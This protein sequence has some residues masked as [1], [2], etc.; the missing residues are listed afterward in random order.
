MAE[1]FAALIDEKVFAGKK[2]IDLLRAIEAETGR[3][4][5]EHPVFDF[6]R[7]VLGDDPEN[8]KK[9]VIAALQQNFY[10]DETSPEHYLLLRIVF[11]RQALTE[12]FIDKLVRGDCGYSAFDSALIRHGAKISNEYNVFYNAWAKAVDGNPV[13]ER[14]KKDMADKKEIAA[15]LQNPYTIVQLNDKGEYYDVPYA[16]FFKKELAGVI[17][18]FDNA[19]KE[20]EQIPKTENHQQAFL[21]YLKH[22]RYTLTESDKSKLDKVNVELD[23]LWM[24][25]RHKIQI[26]HDFETGYGDPLRVKA[27]PDFSLRVADDSA[28]HV[29]D[30]IQHLQDILVTWF[31]KRD[32]PLARAGIFALTNT[33]AAL[34]YLPYVSGMSCHFRFSGQMLPNRPEVK[35]KFGVKIFFDRTNVDRRMYVSHDLI[36]KVF[37]D[38]EPMIAQLNT[39]DTVAYA[40]APHE[41]GHS[42]YGLSHL[43]KD[44][45]ITEQSLYE[46]P[47]A[48]IT[49]LA[50]FSILY[51][52]KEI[53]EAQLQRYLL[54]FMASEIRRFP[55]G[56]GASI[57]PYVVSALRSCQVY[58]KIGLISF[59]ENGEKLKYD[60][61]KSVEF[62]NI[63]RKVFE[64]IL[65]AE[66][67]HSEAKLQAI[68]H[69]FEDESKLSKFLV[70]KLYVPPAKKE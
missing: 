37:V 64:A 35:D 48:E 14:I 60:A 23:E 58:E 68:F 43:G 5:S 63:S 26:C 3:I 55:V 51:E 62:C 20:L 13:A 11:T 59:V 31:K 39:D 38:P 70:A 42:I 25:I 32:K 8:V 66:D 56:P 33:L 53:T 29:N 16:V 30:T 54:N 69:R 65:D 45:N 15:D 34:Y 36:R 17:A 47:R 7:R 41:I 57:R 19:L 9:V 46:E 24:Q 40:I 22:Y 28:R 67:E 21:N 44:M 1:A 49:T 50:L 2:G 18:A 4:F 12:V 61:S 27:I 52:Q 6:H 10:S